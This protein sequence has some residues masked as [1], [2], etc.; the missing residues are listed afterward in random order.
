MDVIAASGWGDDLEVAGS[1]LGDGP[2]GSLL[3]LVMGSAESADVAGAGGTACVPG[4]GVVEVGSPGGLAAA[5][6]A[7]GL[8]A[9]LDVLA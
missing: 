3:H 6:V 8:V 5:G 4:P 9:G 1:G 2:A 7:A